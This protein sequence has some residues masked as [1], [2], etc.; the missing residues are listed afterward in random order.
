MPE[1]FDFEHTH[2]AMFTLLLRRS[3]SRVPVKDALEIQVLKE[4]T[5]SV[6]FG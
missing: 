4:I 1:D 3:F 2:V 6:S 5:V